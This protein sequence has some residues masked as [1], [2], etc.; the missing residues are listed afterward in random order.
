M[1]WL[2][3]KYVNCLKLVQN[4]T[5]HTDYIST[6]LSCS[7]ELELYSLKPLPNTFFTTGRTA[8]NWFFMF[9]W[10]V[11][12][13]S[14]QLF[15]SVLHHLNFKWYRTLLNSWMESVFNRSRRAS[16]RETDK[17]FPFAG[18]QLCLLLCSKPSGFLNNLVKTIATTFSCLTSSNIK[19][20]HSKHRYATKWA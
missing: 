18:I 10:S 17:K 20:I 5:L 4:I 3:C 6:E 2:D 19:S 8:N 7:G 12:T 16:S 13:L 14:I 9:T 11:E 15:R 1:I